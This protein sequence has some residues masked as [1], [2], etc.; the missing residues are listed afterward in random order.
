MTAETA[1]AHYVIR[2]RFEGKSVALLVEDGDG[3]IHIIGAAGL[4]YPLAGICDLSRLGPTLRRLGWIPVPRVEPYR[5]DELRRLL[6]PGG[7][8]MTGERRLPADC[9]AS[10]GARKL[11][12]FATFGGEA[13]VS[14]I[15]RERR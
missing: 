7:G 9:V 2:Y 3:D 4:I 10:T 12:S 6:I 14:P 1:T 8:L 5:L 13:G 15:R 11:A